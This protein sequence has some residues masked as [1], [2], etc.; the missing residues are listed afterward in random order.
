MFRDFNHIAYDCN[1]LIPRT[2]IILACR[3]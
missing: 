1:F 2:D 3:I